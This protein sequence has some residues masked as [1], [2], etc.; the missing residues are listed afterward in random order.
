VT[1]AAS[2]NLGLLRTFFVYIC[3]LGLPPF[4]KDIFGES[5]RLPDV[6]WAALAEDVHD[7]IRNCEGL[8][9]QGCVPRQSVYEFAQ[10]SEV[11]E[12]TPCCGSQVE[13]ENSIFFCMKERTYRLD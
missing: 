12:K 11:P 5:A 6:G 8:V 10:R 3:A 9:L 2:N 4:T 13:P 1:I 7:F